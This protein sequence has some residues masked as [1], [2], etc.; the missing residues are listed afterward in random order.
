MT[1]APPHLRGLRGD[2]VVHADADALADAA[3]ALLSDTSHTTC[4]LTGRF[5]VALSG[6]STPVATFERLVRAPYRDSIDWPVWAIYFS[7]ER[8]VAPDDPAS[9]YRLVHD[10]LLSRV[11]ID[12]ERVHRM[13]ADAPDLDHAADEYAVTLHGDLAEGPQR[14]PRLDCVVLGLGENGHTASLFPGTPALSVNDRWVT[15][16]LADYAPVDRLT[17]TYPTINAAALTVFLVSGT[18]KQ[19]ALHDTARGTTP[20]ARVHPVEGRLIWLLDA[21][22]AGA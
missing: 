19:A 16:G 18:G 12:A 21:A 9:N 20:A 11:P 22:A 4:A 6:G 17:L 15:R 3:A 7:D 5:A 2:V 14:A 1:D 10:H 13:P 8:A